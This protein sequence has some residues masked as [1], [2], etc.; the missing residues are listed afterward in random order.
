[1]I[2]LMTGVASFAIL[3]GCIGCASH[4]G[5]SAPRTAPLRDGVYSYSERPPQSSAVIEGTFTVLADTV[6]LDAHSGICH[7]DLR[8]SSRSGPFVYVCDAVTLYFDRFDPVRKASYRTTRT[9]YDRTQVCDQYNT[10]SA[11]QQVCVHYRTEITER[12][13]PV[14]GL[15]HPVRVEDPTG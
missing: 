9:V 14:S 13:E 1:M 7:Y 12:Q 2:R 5:T 8:S 4:K 6:M 10:N 15:L 11:G 3:A